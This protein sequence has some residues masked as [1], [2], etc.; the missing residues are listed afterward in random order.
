M[1]SNRNFE[2]GAAREMRQGGSNY[3]CCLPA[4]AGFVRPQ[5]A[6]PDDDLTMGR[7]PRNS[8]PRLQ[9]LATSRLLHFRF[10]RSLCQGFE[11]EGFSGPVPKRTAYVAFF[12]ILGS[13]KTKNLGKKNS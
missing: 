4:L 1:Q 5:S 10:Q 13:E 2:K 3:R 7:F 6:L 9:F 8:T 11:M 12:Q